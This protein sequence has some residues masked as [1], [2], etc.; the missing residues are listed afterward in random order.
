MIFRRT[1]WR[2]S[3]NY[4][5]ANTSQQKYLEV[6]VKQTYYEDAKHMRYA[7]ADDFIEIFNEEMRS[8]FLLC[9]LLTADIDKAEHCFVSGLEQCMSESC[10]FL[11]WARLWARR[12]VIKKAIQ[13]ITPA[14]QSPIRPVSKCFNRSSADGVDSTLRDLLELDCLE[15]FVIVITLIERYPDQDCALLLG[16]RRMDI[17]V[18]RAMALRKLSGQAV[19]EGQTEEANR[20]WQSIWPRRRIKAIAAALE[21]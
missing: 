6:E 19:G 12:V 17:V 21:H 9:L 1:L 5:R 11:E 10:S 15:R 16:C 4:R 18:T 13:L 14:R 7:N 20:A 2:L 8:L 3:S